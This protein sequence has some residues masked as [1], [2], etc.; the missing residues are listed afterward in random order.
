MPRSLRTSSARAWLTACGLL[1]SL[2]GRVPGAVIAPLASWDHS[3]LFKLTSTNRPAPPS[4]YVPRSVQALRELGLGAPTNSVT[5][6]IGA[7]AALYA[8]APEKGTNTPESMAEAEVEHRFSDM[9]KE[10]DRM[11]REGRAEE[12]IAMLKQRLNQP[13]P[14]AQRAKI[15]NRI[16]SYYFRAQ[17]YKEALP[18]MREAVRLD[19]Q[20]YATLCNLSAVLMSMNEM[21]EAEFLLKTL[22]ISR[23]QDPRLLFSVFFNRACVASM[24][25]RQSFALE[26]LKNA[27]QTDPHSTLASMGDPQL[28]NIRPSLEFFDLKSRLETIIAPT[29]EVVP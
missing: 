14:P 24:Q 18:Y 28:D 2:A 13:M 11:S 12:A 27:A 5:N 10:V 16:A 22:D 29:A 23:I 3:D 26:Q 21:R 15:N 20:D 7:A 25:E 4:E 17:R 1:A 8:T 19:P 9:L 6:G